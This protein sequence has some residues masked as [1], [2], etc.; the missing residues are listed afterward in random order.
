M[1]SQFLELADI[2]AELVLKDIK[3]VHLS[4]YPPTGHVRIAA[5]EHMSLENV[6]AYAATR[7]PWIRK[8]QQRILKQERESIRDFV[9]GESHYL[10]GKRYLLKLL[11]SP[12]TSVAAKGNKIV[13]SVSGSTT[14]EV[15]EEIL[16]RWHRQEVQK[17][18]AMTL[19]EWEARLGVKCQKLL[20]RRMRTKWGSCSPSKG[21]IRL[22]TELAKKPKDCAEY[23]LV[24]E[25]VHL[26]VPNHGPH[27]VQLMDKFLPS[28]RERRERLNALPVRHENW[29]W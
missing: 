18:A 22:N 11:E 7:I 8:Q 26:L 17:L 9:S 13:L 4:V 14:R 1:G 23:I 28:W 2:R 3:H 25:L 10:W 16:E 27:F 6:R 20:V 15:R 29:V 12:R 24:H 19:P 21:T 5:P